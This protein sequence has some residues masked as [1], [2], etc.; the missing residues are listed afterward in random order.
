MTMETRPTAPGGG[1]AYHLLLAGVAV[2]ALGWLMAQAVSWLLMAAVVAIAVWYIADFVSACREFI[3]AWRDR[4]SDPL[5][6]MAR[7][8]RRVEKA[9]GCREASS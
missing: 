5:R 9:R 4:S 2:L 1:I 7:W 6:Q 8:A 3:L